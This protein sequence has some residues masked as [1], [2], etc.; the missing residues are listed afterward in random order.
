LEPVTG[1]DASATAPAP[2]AKAALPST[3]GTPLYSR[4]AGFVEVVD[5]MVKVGDS[6]T[7]GSVVAAVEAMKA[8]ND[9]KAPCDGTVTAIHV[10]IGDEID[11]SKPIMIIS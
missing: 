6:V 7:K 2:A 9:I 11:S 8:R 3:K 4:F 5:V 10:K 1:A